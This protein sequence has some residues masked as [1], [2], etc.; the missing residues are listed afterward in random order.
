MQAGRPGAKSAQS[1]SRQPSRSNVL[2]FAALATT[3]LS[4]TLIGISMIQ[5]QRFASWD[6]LIP[7]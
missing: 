3:I 5:Q 2:A 7:A 1:D 6:Y 4:Y